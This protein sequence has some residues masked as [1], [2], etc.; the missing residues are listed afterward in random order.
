VRLKSLVVL[1][2]I[3][4]TCVGGA[5]AAEKTEVLVDGEKITLA[6]YA[7][8]LIG[9]GNVSVEIAPYKK[10]AGGEGAIVLFKGVESDWDGKA[11]NYSI[12]PTSFGVDYVLHDGK[13][14]RHTL[15]M[16]NRDGKTTYMLYLPDAPEITLVPSDGAAQ[17]TTPAAILKEYQ[18]QQAKK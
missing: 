3:V 10:P 14:E 12:E 6:R 15:T 17:L 2:L 8:V 7:K 4:G 5:I 11:F 13:K 1:G 18:S 16:R 9:Q